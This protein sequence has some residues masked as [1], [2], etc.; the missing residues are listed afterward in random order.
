MSSRLLEFSHMAWHQKRLALNYVQPQMVPPVTKV[1]LSH[2]YSQPDISTL[3]CSPL[4]WAEL[5]C[6]CIQ[7]NPYDPSSACCTTL[8]WYFQCND[9]CFFS[10]SLSWILSGYRLPWSVCLSAN[11]SAYLLLHTKIKLR[12]QKHCLHQC[13][14]LSHRFNSSSYLYSC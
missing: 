9:I 14:S 8:R 4:H 10:L 5:C 13:V 6:P 7:P 1:T 2:G 3:P 12:K 11:I